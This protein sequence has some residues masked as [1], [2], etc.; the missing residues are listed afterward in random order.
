MTNLREVA[1]KIAEYNH[2]YP[3]YPA[4]LAHCGCKNEI[5]SV[6]REFCESVYFEGKDAGI[7]EVKSEIREGAFEM[8]Y[9]AARAEALEEAAKVVE[10][11]YWNVR[12]EEVEAERWLAAKIRALVQV[13]HPR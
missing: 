10:A 2:K 7:K 4:G 6:L 12:A 13:Q 1:E 11:E 3:H 9:S 8:G 5:E